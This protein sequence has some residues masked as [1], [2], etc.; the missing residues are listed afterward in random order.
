MV[1]SYRI[2]DQRE[3][4]SSRSDIL[5]S[6][7]RSQTD[8]EGSVVFVTEVPKELAGKKKNT[9][10]IDSTGEAVRRITPAA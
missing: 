2:R 10:E 6:L 5:S 7:H 4:N 9:K 8:A 3:R 1:R